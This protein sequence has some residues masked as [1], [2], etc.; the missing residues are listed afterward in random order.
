MPVSAD[1]LDNSQLRS[2]S[3]ITIC[4]LPS[5]RMFSIIIDW[6]LGCDPRSVVRGPWSSPGSL[7][8]ANANNRCTPVVVVVVGCWMG[9]RANAVSPVSLERI[10]K[11][12]HLQRQSPSRPGK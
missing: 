2:S 8:T 3:I 7:I 9:V 6:Q 5:S 4:I 12:L 11:N 10:S 1:K